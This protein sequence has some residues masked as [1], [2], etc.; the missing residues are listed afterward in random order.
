MRGLLL[1]KGKAVREFVMLILANE[2]RLLAVFRLAEVNHAVSVLDDEVE[3]RLLLGFGVD[4]APRIVF[5]LDALDTQRLH[6]LRNVRQA[7]AL[8]REAH[9]CINT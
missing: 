9:P 5:R 3:L 8:K 1:E 4:A 6:D 2:I 7:N